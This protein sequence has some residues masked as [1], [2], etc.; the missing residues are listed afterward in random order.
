MVKTRTVVQTRT[1]A[2][3]YF[4][5][6]SK[7][8]GG[9]GEDSENEQE[10]INEQ[11]E[12]EM[13]NQK[14]LISSFANDRNSSCLESSVIPVKSANLSNSAYSIVNS[15]NS[16]SN[17]GSPKYKKMQNFHP[18]NHPT[19]INEYENH[20]KYAND[21]QSYQS[22]VVNSQ[23]RGRLVN[24]YN[25]HPYAVAYQDIS[26][27][28]VPNH[29]DKLHL[30]NLN[31]GGKRKHSEINSTDIRTD[32]SIAIVRSK[33]PQSQHLDYPYQ[34]PSNN[35]IN[36]QNS[37][38]SDCY[39][40]PS[41]TFPQ[42]LSCDSLMEYEGEGAEV[43][44]RMKEM[45]EITTQKTFPQIPR[46]NLNSAVVSVSSLAS[47]SGLGSLGEVERKSSVPS[48]M[49]TKNHDVLP[50]N[51]NVY[52]N[53]HDNEHENIHENEHEN[54]IHGDVLETPWE[55]ETRT[56]SRVHTMSTNDEHDSYSFNSMRL[57]TSSEQRDF[58]KRVTALLDQG[59]QGLSSLEALLAASSSQG[60]GHDQQHDQREHNN[61]ED[62]SGID[63]YQYVYF[64]LIFDRK[65]VSNECYFF[66]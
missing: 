9:C 36:D 22:A 28:S 41:V 60:Q 37:D 1:H 54:E 4:Q 58:L 57:V 14:V 34:L 43:L 65:N 8:G 66:P 26:A 51:R 56:S 44:F 61:S 64:R 53:E 63:L 35:M 40:D 48:S 6:V 13:R 25:Y 21:D 5:K 15:H 7:T 59:V 2:Q 32:S 47:S 31:Q 50:Y 29:N 46:N 23:E 19:S 30:Q 11:P 42:S 16:S 10:V 33:V 55:S 52:G 45:T 49:A 27:K 38:R 18:N 17:G 24:S 20:S 12:K 62:G 39:H 3:K